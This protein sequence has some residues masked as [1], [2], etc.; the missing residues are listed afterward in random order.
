[1]EE[2]DDRKLEGHIGMD[3]MDPINNA[4]SIASTEVLS[5]LSHILT[6]EKSNSVRLHDHLL[7]GINALR[8]SDLEK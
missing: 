1:M 2:I 3:V 8:Q 6:L 7:R 5:L 4:S